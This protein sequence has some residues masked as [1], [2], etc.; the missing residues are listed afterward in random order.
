[1]D[2]EKKAELLKA[3]CDY[4][5]WITNSHDVRK[6]EVEILPELVKSIVLLA[7]A[8]VKKRSE[9]YGHPL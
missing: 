7:E 9:F 2:S 4:A 8:D 6:A 3:L 5:V 1:M